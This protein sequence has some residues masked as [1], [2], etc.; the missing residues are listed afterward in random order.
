[1]DPE[2]IANE[3]DV[4]HEQ[5]LIN[6]FDIYK[7]LVDD[8]YRKQVSDYYDIIKSTANVFEMME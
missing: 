1:M 7:Y 3:L 6:N 8:E 4:A 2:Y 5:D